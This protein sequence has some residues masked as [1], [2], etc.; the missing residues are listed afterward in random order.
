MKIQ[1]S[2]ENY[3]ETILVLKRRLGAVRSIDVANELGFKK[4]SISVA[5]KKLR[6]NGYI[7]VDEDG[8]IELTPEGGERAEQVYERHCV[9][10]DFLTRI[11]VSPAT[12]QEDACRIEHVLSAQTFA[13]IRAHLAQMPQ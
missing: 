5:M 13:C 9:L 4:P 10:V 12:A 8:H 11:G 1:E 3:L 7:T 2:A 6:E